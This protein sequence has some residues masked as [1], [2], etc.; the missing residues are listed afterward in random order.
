MHDLQPND[1]P[2]MFRDNQPFVYEGQT[3]GSVGQHSIIAYGNQR[4]I[5]QLFVDKKEINNGAI[6]VRARSIKVPSQKVID[7]KASYAIF[8]K[9]VGFTD[10]DCKTEDQEPYEKI[11]FRPYNDTGLF[12]L[13]GIFLSGELVWKLGGEEL[14]DLGDDKFDFWHWA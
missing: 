6:Q 9:V 10:P 3:R 13:W 11:Y 8:T 7:Q 4:D 2:G 14:Q 12:V 5:L 1:N